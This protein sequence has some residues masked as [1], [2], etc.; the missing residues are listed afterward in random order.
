MKRLFFVGLILWVSPVFAGLTAED[1]ECIAASDLIPEIRL[2]A[3]YALVNHYAATKSEAELLALARTGKSE[4]VRL[5]ASLALSQKWLD[6]GKKRDELMRIVTEEE[7]AEVRAAAVPALMTAIVTDKADALLEL[8]KTGATEELQ[9]AAAKAYF[10]K[11]RATFNRAK[12]EAICVDESLPGAYRK[13]AAELLAG[14]YLFPEK[15]A[16]SRTELEK[17]ALENANKYLRYAAAV[18]LVNYLVEESA[19]ALH[20]KV[21]ALFLA[22]GVSEEYRWAYTRALGLKWAAGL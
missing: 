14:H 21:V 8:A 2:A 16:L 12:L 10:Q 6:A 9:Y 19:D 1:F 18:A 20:K 22:S 3:G 11:T 7:S 4:A 5:A 17:Q 15:T 13:A